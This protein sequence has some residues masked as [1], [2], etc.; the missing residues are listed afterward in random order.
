MAEITIPVQRPVGAD[1]LLL[2]EDDHVAQLA[3]AL[4]NLE[5]ALGA[6]GLAPADLVAIRISTTNRRLFDDAA[7]VLTQRLAEHEVRPAIGVHEVSWLGQAG[8]TIAVGAT[9]RTAELVSHKEEQS[10]T[11]ELTEVPATVLRGLCEGRVYLPG[12]PGYDLARTPWAVHV[13][14]RP[15]AVAVPHSAQ[16]VADVVRAAGAA[17]LRIA[18]QS[19]GH[20]AGA[21]LGADLSDVVLVRL[22]EFTG[23][24]I[25]PERRLARV[26]GGTL[27]QT[28]VEAAAPHGLAALHGSSPDVAVA[29]YT[30][31]GGLSWYGRQHGLAAHHLHAAEL[32][33]ADGCLVRTDADHRPDLFWA[34]K[35]G[36]GNLGVVTALEFE[37]L[38]IADVYAGMLL[39]P[40]EKAAEVTHRWAEWTRTAPD[41]VTT[42]LRLMSFPPLP[43][44]PPFLSGRRLVVID[45]AVLGSD[46][47]AAE[48][49]APLRDLGPE[50][51]TFGRM[52]AAALTRIHMDPEGPTPSVANATA[53]AELP[54]DAVDALLRIAGPDSGSSLLVAEIR[55][56]G[57][58]LGRPGDAALA[59]LPG[60][61]LGFF[62][63]IAPTPDL[64]A[65]GRADADRAVEALVPWADAGRYL[66]FDDNAVDTSA[67]YSPLAWRRL[68]A[69]RES[70]DPC[71][72]LLANHAI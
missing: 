72:R 18:P 1:G 63:A 51:D 15:A 56:L 45:G 59:R 55:Q 38:P 10:M 25:D 49:L 20:G 6:S 37:L 60:N 44:L 41:A 39:W 70:V 47:Q 24:S 53:L 54:S 2:H 26:L 36:G 11:S 14:Q 34:L 57:G 4:E 21:F 19:S 42:S 35:G 27:W 68:Q 23:V 66:N 33:L 28:V 62:L 5:R 3:L 7:E 17:G 22:N 61:Y 32:V 13:D 46:E 48:L 58:A 30:L 40:A 29:G 12:D 64:A 67:G 8:M 43:E 52:P 65:L 31:G 50:M 9:A 16:E 71:H 69:V